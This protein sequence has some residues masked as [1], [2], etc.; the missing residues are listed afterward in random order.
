VLVIG[1]S[2]GA[3]SGA[4]PAALGIG[5]Q[6]ELVPMQAGHVN[7]GQALDGAQAGTDVVHA[8]SS[9]AGS[10]QSALMPA[11]ATILR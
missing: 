4:L 6:D 11:F 1:S 2:S 5:K 7:A 3:S 10:G 8:W 9:C